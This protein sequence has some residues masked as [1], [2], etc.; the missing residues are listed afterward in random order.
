[1][2]YRMTQQSIRTCTRDEMSLERLEGMSSNLAPTTTYLRPQRDWLAEAYNLAV[3]PDQYI[4][5]LR[6][7]HLL[8]RLKKG[9]QGS[10]RVFE[11]LISPEDVEI[12]TGKSSACCFEHPGEDKCDAFIHLL[13]HN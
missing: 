8:K 6:T 3:I 4:N 11:A 13:R 7:S 12:L 5:A 2:R 10:L 9:V 1:M